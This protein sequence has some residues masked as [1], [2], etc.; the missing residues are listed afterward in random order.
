MTRSY[1]LGKSGLEGV[2][3]EVGLNVSF[4]AAPV[5]GMDP[6]HFAKQLFD[7]WDAWLLRW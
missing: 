4:A 2:C 7:F 3:W 1:L 6:D 5:T